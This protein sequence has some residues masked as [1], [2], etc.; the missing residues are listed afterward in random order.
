MLAWPQSFLAIKT[1]ITFNFALIRATLIKNVLTKRVVATRVHVVVRVRP[2]R[3]LA[4]NQIL[5]IA[6]PAFVAKVGAEVPIEGGLRRTA[7][8]AMFII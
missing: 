4:V 7:T 8:L 5:L 3:R 2:K 1:S 6:V